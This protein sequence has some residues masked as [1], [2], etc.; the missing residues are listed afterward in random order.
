MGK[1]IIGYEPVM[2]DVINQQGEVVARA[3]THYEPV[4]DEEL[5]GLFSQVNDPS[6]QEEHHRLTVEEYNRMIGPVK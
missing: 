2:L 5:K 1:V 4:Y 3:V 6:W